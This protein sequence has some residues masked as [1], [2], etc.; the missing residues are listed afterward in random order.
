MEMERR[1]ILAF[2]LAPAVAPAAV[3]AWALATG[4]RAPES[5]VLASIYGAFTYGTAVALGLPFFR[6][7]ERK[8]WTRWWQY[9]V[10]GAVIGLAPLLI[11]SLA[12]AA[13]PPGGR[14]GL[15]FVGVGVL[16]ATVFWLIAL[17]GRA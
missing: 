2:A 17:K 10:A 1:V 3:A 6:L 16:S 15:V 5:L 13:P 8:G 11:I 14:V 4:V 12:A 9:A 7:A